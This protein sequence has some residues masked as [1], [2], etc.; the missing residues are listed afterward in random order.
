MAAAWAWDV[1]FGD[2]DMWGMQAY[3][4]V[5]VKIMVTLGYPKYRDYRDKKR[6]R[7]TIGTQ[8]GTII[9]TTTHIAVLVLVLHAR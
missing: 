6:C 2:A 9:S 7:T 4:W 3:T 8:K 1:G 5:V